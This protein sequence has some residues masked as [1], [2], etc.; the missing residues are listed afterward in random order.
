MMKLRNKNKKASTP[1]VVNYSG[2]YKVVGTRNVIE[3]SNI[4]GYGISGLYKELS[5]ERFGC[6]S[7][8]FITQAE[9]TKKIENGSY[10]RTTLEIYQE[11]VRKKAKDIPDLFN[12]IKP[13]DVFN[14]FDGNKHTILKIER[15]YRLDSRHRENYISNDKN[16]YGPLAYEKCY[17]IMYRT[18]RFEDADWS[19]DITND[20]FLDFYNNGWLRGYGIE[21][22]SRANKLGSIF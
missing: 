3:L 4:V 11:A 21:S 22:D 19:K 16:D 9:L 10:E 17:R 14:K 18:K 1:E 7:F 5:S 12:D 8:N 2:F 20:S 6:E 15:T 13:G